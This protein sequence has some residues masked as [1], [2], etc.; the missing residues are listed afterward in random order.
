ME[1]ASSDDDSDDEMSAD[2][3][4]GLYAQLNVI[5]LRKHFQNCMTELSAVQATVPAYESRHSFAMP[6]PLPLREPVN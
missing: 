6:P 4:E 3:L 2:E 1:Y 5:N